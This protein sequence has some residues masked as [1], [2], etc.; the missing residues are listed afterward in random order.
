MAALHGRYYCHQ[1]HFTGENTEAQEDL[2]TSLK[3][4][5]Q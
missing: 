1:P 5:S 3:L 2:V 4:H